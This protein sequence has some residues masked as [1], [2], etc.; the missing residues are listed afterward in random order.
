MEVSYS[1]GGSGAAAVAVRAP[2]SEEYGA[3]WAKNHTRRSNFS[4]YRGVKIRRPS[5]SRPWRCGC[6][7]GS[8]AAGRRQERVA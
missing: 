3:R 5:P 6:C 1:G 8:P 2:L 4:W 7:A